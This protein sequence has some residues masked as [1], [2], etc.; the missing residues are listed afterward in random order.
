M[1]IGL[2][3]CTTALLQSEG[4]SAYGQAFEEIRIV[5]HDGAKLDWFGMAVELA[6]SFIFIGSPGDNFNIQESGSVYLYVL[7]NRQVTFK[8]KLFPPNPKNQDGFGA[9]IK[10]FKNFLFIGAP[11]AKRDSLHGG[12]VFVYELKN[13]EFIPRQRLMVSNANVFAHFGLSLAVTDRFLLIGAPDFYENN[14]RTGAAYFFKKQDTSWV[15]TQFVLPDDPFHGENFGHAVALCD[16]FAFIGNPNEMQTYLYDGSVSVYVYRN[17]Q[18][19]FIQKLAASDALPHDA[20][21]SALDCKQNTL[22]VGAPGNVYSNHPGRVYIFNYNRALRQWEEVQ[23]LKAD[24]SFNENAFG[25]RLALQGDSLVITDIEDDWN[26]LNTGAA[27][28]YREQENGWVQVSKITPSDGGV[29]DRFGSSVAID[30][31]RILIGDMEK[32]VSRK[33]TGAAYLYLPGK[34]VGIEPENELYPAQVELHAPFP[35]P[36]NP[37]TQ[38][39]FTLPKAMSVS[40]T[41]YNILG[42]KVA[43]LYRGRL[44]P[45]THRMTFEAGNLPAGVYTVVLR[46]PQGLQARKMVLVR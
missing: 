15:Q 34:I 11:L 45:G 8:R 42:E 24:S 38:I 19:V 44:S 26:G 10:F 30:K 35:N 23:I 13:R 1:A 17:G 33:R 29:V 36:F 27:Y 25:V 37:S 16:S 7:K 18:W 22:I 6:D 28:F 12:A 14:M 3:F 39:T 2:W 40:L 32:L 21:G 41:V 20:F 43:L 31:E 46:T 9:S 4:S 5:P